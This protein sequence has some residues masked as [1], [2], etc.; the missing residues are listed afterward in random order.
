MAA[1]GNCTINVIFTPSA[2]DSRNATLNI[3]D[4][5]IPSPQTIA[6]LGTGVQ[7]MA[8]GI[9]PPGLTFA[10]QALY[11]A[12][13]AKTVTVTNND[14]N[15][16]LSLGTPV[17]TGDFQVAPGGC[18]STLGAGSTC[19]IGA[20]FTPT[21]SGIRTGTLTVSSNGSST[22]LTVAL[23]GTGGA[24]AS[25][26]TTLLSLGNTNV[27]ESS[28]AQSVTLSNSSAFAVNLTGVSMSGVSASQFTA[29]N[30]CGATV[31]ASGNC[32]VSVIFKPTA[33]GPQTATMTIGSDAA[34]PF[35]PV[36]LSGTGTTPAVSLSTL[37][38]VFSGQALNV[39]STPLP[40]TLTN[41]GTGALNFSGGITISGANAGDFAQSNNCGAQV[42]AGASCTINVTFTPKALNSRVATLSI[43]D[44]AV[45]SPQS[46]ALSGSGG[47]VATLGPN[48]TFAAPNN[49]GTT[50]QAQIVTFGNQSNFAVSVQSVAISGVAAGDF[51]QTNNCGT[52]VSAL[53][54]CTINVSFTPTATGNRNATL[55]VTSNAAASPQSVSLLGVG[56]A[57]LVT[58]TPPTTLSF[59][60][61]P[62]NAA[63]SAMPITL[64]N[65]GS[66]P[67]NIPIGGITITGT[68]A[69]D[70]SQT[71]NC[72]TQVLAKAS[73][74]I[75]VTFTPSGLNN[76]NA[77]LNIADDAIPNPQT[78]ALLGAGVQVQAPKV[79][80]PSLTFT[81]QPLN[82]ASAAKTVTVTNTDPT[83]TLSLSAPV[84]TGDF[85]VVP[86]GCGATLG[87]GL[88]CQIGATFTPTAAG[89]RTGS[90]TITSNGSSTPLTVPLTGTGGGIA[91]VSPTSLNLGS[92]NVGR[93]SPAQSV[94]LTNSSAFPVNITGVSMS[95]AAAAEYAATNNCGTIVPASGNC[96]VSVIF[97]PTATG[98]QT[99]TMTIGSDA[100]TPFA[101]VGLSGIGTTPVVT[102]APPSNL[103]FKNQP[104]NSASGPQ[105]ITLTN[106]GTGPLNIP[107]GGITIGGAVPGD[108]SQ[109]NTCGTQ[110]AAGTSCTISVIFTPTALYS[111][112]ATLSIA[113]DAIPNP[114]IIGLAGAGVQVDAPT[115]APPSL[116][117]GNQALT[118]ASAA[119]MVTVTNPD[120]TYTLSL[121]AIAATGDFQVVTVPGSCGPSVAANSSCLIALTFTPTASGARTG[122]LTV[123]SNGSSAP[124]VVTL[125]GT[126]GAAGSVSPTSLNMGSVNLGGSSPSQSVTL[127]NS[128]AF[129]VNI[130]GVSMSGAAASQFA[131][132]NN[133]GTIVPASSTCTVSVI[134]TP[135]A[136]GSQTA[137]MTI[138]SD[139]ATPFTPVGLTGTGTSPV[140][141]LSTV[142]L[143]FAS[144]VLNIASTAQPIT[145]SNT[146]SGAL[147]LT[148][149]IAISG[150]NA[151]D[152]AQT[153]NCGLQVAAGGSC[154]INVTFT[155]TALNSRIAV[156][157]LNDDAAN[158][159]QTVALSGTGVAGFQLSTTSLAFGT[160][161]VNT[162]SSAQT[163]TLTN[164]ATSALSI[165]AIGFSGANASDFSGT[166]T[167]PTSPATLAGSASCTISVFFTPTQAVAESATLTVTGSGTNSPAVALSGTGTSATTSTVPFTVTAQS[168]GVSITEGARQP[169]PSPWP[170]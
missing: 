138:G 15:Y 97:T 160:Q 23:I 60:N 142:S 89:T 96:T 164:S 105:V 18:G 65:S 106:A 39:A 169:T 104:L 17:A 32:T 128:S 2:I 27:G 7:V 9:A 72:G 127:R 48:L 13:A 92:A 79:A 50:T 134:F 116:A 37:S 5:A 94:T 100:S 56:T 117:F 156:I 78:V 63:S 152:F 114:Q 30:N 136:T 69:G 153:N 25:V 81:N 101:P 150:A 157:T 124:L 14:L 148:S 66:G 123:V 75:S 162:T 34:T 85:Q 167:C 140:V 143:T 35:A 147:N 24:L 146:G 80:P 120:P 90:L 58:T 110:V 161:Q 108:F 91:S 103:N 42:A 133:C 41:P 71:N 77:M 99:A 22:P 137:T 55:T 159:P 61:Q 95:G 166:T 8:P 31:P 33:S 47:A 155:P 54:K 52:S 149:A 83:Y 125:T 59:P 86:G 112:S 62:L 154:V 141:S 12:S 20:T 44:D 139:A 170:R 19:Q 3:A 43:A 88:A 1:G 126:G 4:N 67:L 40:I 45:G 38:L 82:Q 130:T 11:V 113:D 115:I 111:R 29:T 132:T 129:P 118:V 10:N 163:V 6:L 87:A 76:R 93:T 119:K 158:S 53:S 46:V 107:V 51:T 98:I 68:A 21:A 135:T 70:F 73:C 144:Q 84:A 145:L 131:A 121:T 64:I 57:P 122:T 36:G 102:L 165:T 26:N 16:T 168:T 28:V 151:G 49:V 74:T 109:T